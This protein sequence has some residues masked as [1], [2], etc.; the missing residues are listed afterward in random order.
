MQ[1]KTQLQNV[2]SCCKRIQP[3]ISSVT[4]WQDDVSKE[5]EILLECAV[6]AFGLAVRLRVVSSQ[7]G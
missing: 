7:E 4:I 1:E 3:L 2:W 5:T 6:C